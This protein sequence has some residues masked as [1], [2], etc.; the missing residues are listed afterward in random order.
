M[1]LGY[2]APPIGLNLLLASYR[3]NKPIV[4]VMRAVIPM[5]LVQFVGVLLVTYLPQLTTFLPHWFKH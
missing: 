3:F 4:E 5:L 2:L 1:E